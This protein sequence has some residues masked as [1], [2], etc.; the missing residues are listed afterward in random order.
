M[1]IDELVRS[2]GGIYIG[3]PLTLCNDQFRWDSEKFQQLL[4]NTLVVV[5]CSWENWGSGNFINSLYD[6]LEKFNINFLVL[7]HI[8][9]DHLVRPRMLFHPFWYHSVVMYSVI[10]NNIDP[11]NIQLVDQKKYRLSCLHGN[12]R[13]HRI[14]NYIKL[15]KFLDDPSMLIKIF[16]NPNGIDSRLDEDYVLSEEHTSTWKEL[17]KNLQSREEIQNQENIIDV[18][19]D[20]TTPAHSDSYIN[21]VTETTI[22]TR[23][24]QSEKIWKP[25]LSGQMFVILGNPGA[26]GR[27]RKQGVDTYDDFIDHDYYDKEQDFETRLTKLHYLI[28]NL[29]SQDLLSINTALHSRR[30]KNIENFYAGNFDQQYNDFIRIIKEHL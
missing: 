16:T 18:G 11:A 12:P 17:N 7:T 3:Y 2:I 4:G 6:E 15:N 24:Q 9:E 20:V 13:P 21:L 10:R 28:E 29:I 25:I 19:T 22:I 8:Y 30:L 14:L 26:V 23:L 27:L 1:L 5:D